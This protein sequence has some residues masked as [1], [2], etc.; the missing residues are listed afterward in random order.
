[1]KKDKRLPDNYKLVCFWK[2]KYFYLKKI[3]SYQIELNDNN[4]IS[5]VHVKYKDFIFTTY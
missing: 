3:S 5:S 4:L 1:M 2:A